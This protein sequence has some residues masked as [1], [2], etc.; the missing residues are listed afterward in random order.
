MKIIESFKHKAAKILLARWLKS[1][2]PT[3]TEVRFYNG[4]RIYFIADI[5]C[6][7]KDEPF[8]IYEVVHSHGIDFRKLSRIQQWSYRNALT[9]QVY[10]VKAEW[11]LRQIRQPKSIKFID[12]TTII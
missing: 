6:F 1:E 11:I 10:E 9:L 3:K 5:V 2:Y 8:A 7:D 12:Y 4:D